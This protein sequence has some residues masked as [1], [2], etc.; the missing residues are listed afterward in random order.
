VEESFKYNRFCKE[1]FSLK[2][3]INTDP[4]FAVVNNQNETHYL[5]IDKKPWYLPA[6]FCHL[7]QNFLTPGIKNYYDA[8]VDGWKDFESKA[9]KAENLDL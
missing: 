6:E 8:K 1:Y 7:V 4:D 5:F 2:K 9:L 3:E